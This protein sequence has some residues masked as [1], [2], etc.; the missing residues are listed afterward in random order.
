MAT[1]ATSTSMAMTEVMAT[2]TATSSQVQENCH[3]LILGLGQTAVASARQRNDLKI[4]LL[5]RFEEG[6]GKDGQKRA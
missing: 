6:E 1:A 3:G 4:P 5:L 2:V